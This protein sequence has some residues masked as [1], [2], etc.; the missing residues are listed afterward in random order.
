MRLN[1]E[2]LAQ[3]AYLDGVRLTF[4][5]RGDDL[6]QQRYN[7]IVAALSEASGFDED[8]VRGLLK[9]SR[10]R[11]GKRT[12]NELEAYF[13]GGVLARHFRRA[14]LDRYGEA[15]TEVQMKFHLVERYE[16]AH[17]AFIDATYAAAGQFQPKWYGP[18]G[19]GARN[20]RAAGTKGVTFGNQKSDLHVTVN[21]YR[22]ERTGVEGHFRGKQLSKVKAETTRRAGGRDA[23]RSQEQVSTAVQLEAAHRTA[24]RFLRAV[25]SRGIV[26]TD[27]FIGASYVSWDK[28][29]HDKGFDLLNEEEERQAVMF[30]DAPGF[31][32]TDDREGAT[33][34]GE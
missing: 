32:S 6:S 15:I 3:N 9:W 2:T 22:G 27:Y 19:A 1:E 33:F 14:G 21:K 29:L 34:E 23:G 18:A 30:H 13:I 8:K 20:K 16:G 4:T 25:R 24:R 5:Y 12:K 11:S 7:G 17:N 10:I 31:F 28:P 26:F